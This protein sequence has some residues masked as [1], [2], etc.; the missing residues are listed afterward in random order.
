MKSYLSYAKEFFWTFLRRRVEFQPPIGKAYIWRYNGSRNKLG[1]WPENSWTNDGTK[2]K[3][4][5]I[6]FKLVSG[7]DMKDKS[8]VAKPYFDNFMKIFTANMLSIMTKI[9]IW[10]FICGNGEVDA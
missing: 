4:G 7:Y 2:I 5:I 3:F 8:T 1:R 6:N 10:L 9:S